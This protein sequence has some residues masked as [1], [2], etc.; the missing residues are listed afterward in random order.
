[1]SDLPT[2]TILM[3]C[4]NGE[5]FIAEAVESLRRQNYP[6]LEHLVLDACSTDRSLDLLKSFP[7]VMVVSE[8]DDGAHDALNK[9]LARATGDIIGFLAVDDVCPE[10]ALMAVGEAF[11]ARPDIDVVV[12]HSIVFEDDD[13]GRR[14][15]IFARK[16]PKGDGLWLPELTFG[17]P[18]FFG[19]FFRRGVFDRVGFF[20]NSYNFSADRHFLMR[21]AL[22]KV[23]SARIDR[24]AILYRMHAGSQT[25]NRQMRN[26]IPISKEYVL[27]GRELAAAFDADPQA[28]DVLLAWHVFEACK[29]T[30]R[31]LGRGNIVPA[32]KTIIGLC[33]RRPLWPLDLVR[34]LKLRRE[35]ASL[36]PDGGRVSGANG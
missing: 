24:P 36:D 21:L 27:M 8:P 29:L 13:S 25:I 6:G 14:R 17:V 12:G 26:L 28:R 1:M 34:G 16:H 3:P 22:K 11:A 33:L 30:V 10:G 2:I 15:Q 7:G 19:C 20:D 9:G 31:L 5:R 18:G 32:L 35:V 23:R 4:L